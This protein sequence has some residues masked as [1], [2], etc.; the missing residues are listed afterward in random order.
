MA[1]KTVE[2]LMEEVS[3]ALTDAEYLI[4][5]LDRIQMAEVMEE[6]LPEIQFREKIGKLVQIVAELA[7]HEML[8][9]FESVAQ[10]VQAQGRANHHAT[11]SD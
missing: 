7:N 4:H 5:R 6:D 11:N 9:G 1:I 2:R 3:T 8:G 10:A